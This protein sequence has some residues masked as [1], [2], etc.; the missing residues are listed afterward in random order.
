MWSQTFKF[1]GDL[2]LDAVRKALHTTIHGVWK[3]NPTKAPLRTFL[4]QLKQSVNV[5]FTKPPA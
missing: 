3:R 4:G 1:G 5:D 2:K